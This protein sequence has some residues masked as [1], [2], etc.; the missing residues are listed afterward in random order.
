MKTSF[1]QNLALLHFFLEF[2]K[3]KGNKYYEKNPNKDI[4]TKC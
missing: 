3:N 4:K 2:K 1:H